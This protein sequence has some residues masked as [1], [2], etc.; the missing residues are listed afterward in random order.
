MEDFDRKLGE[1]IRISAKKNLMV[2]STVFSNHIDFTLF[3]QDNPDT[4]LWK[5]TIFFGDNTA[6]DSAINIVKN[7]V[8]EMYEIKFND[9]I[10]NIDL[11]FESKEE[12]VE[13][14]KELYKKY[15]IALEAKSVYERVGANKNK[16]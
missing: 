15:G 16:E 1:L 8:V 7:R 12:A 14:T 11:L 10:F 3:L 4:R 5:G 6:I 2:L 13:K 9:Q